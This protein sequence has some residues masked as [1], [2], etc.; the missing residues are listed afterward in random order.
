MPKATAKKAKYWSCVPEAI[1][2]GSGRSTVATPQVEEKA[3]DKY[4]DISSRGLSRIRDAA[5]A[6]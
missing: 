5:L 1:G 6:V 4:W 3:Q 2:A